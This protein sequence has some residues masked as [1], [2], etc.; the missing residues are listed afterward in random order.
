MRDSHTTELYGYGTMWCITVVSRRLS[1][2]VVAGS[3]L[4]CVQHAPPRSTPNTRRIT[5]RKP[6]YAL[7]PCARSA[8]RKRAI[9]H[10]AGGRALVSRESLSVSR[11]AA[12]PRR[13]TAYSKRKA[14]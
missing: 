5:N 12:A 1:C 13:P 7:G 10:A 9:G 11:P 14:K 2:V 8:N 6:M 3:A 4:Q